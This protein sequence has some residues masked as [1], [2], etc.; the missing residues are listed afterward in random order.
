MGRDRAQ[1]SCS[2]GLPASV[3]GL[4]LIRAAVGALA[5]GSFAP[6]ILASEGGAS[7]FIPGLS[8]PLGGLLPPPGAY[9]D[10]TVYFYKGELKGGR[11]TPLGGNIVSDVKVDLWADFATG[12][13]VTPAEILG[14]NLAFAV[15]VPFGEPLVRAGAIIS[16]PLL[17]RLIGRPL[18]LGLSDEALNF[19][20]PVV[21]SIIG[22]HLGKWHWKITAS[23]S[24]PAGAYRPGELSNVALNRWIGDVSAGVTYLD[25]ELGIDLS[26]VGGF[27][28]NGENPDTNYNSG[29]EL[30]LEAGLT[31]FL[32][33]E[34]S[35][36]AIGAHY[37]QVTGDRGEGARLGPYKGR[38]TAVG[39]GLGYTFTLGHTP[40]STRVKVL[41]EVDVENRPQGTIGWVQVSFPLWT[42]PPSHSAA[43]AP[44]RARY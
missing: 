39:G 15:S 44:V 18:A 36:S 27:T 12:L 25:P 2:S 3:K 8:V 19:G 23:A 32:T 11:R 33:K 34:L 28:V 41:R 24:I 16:G 26:A 38:V 29:E 21:S 5:I 42:P 1:H 40:V 35:V 37:Q 17:N 6:P 13:W 22:W 9:F 31:K 4:S 20:D 7:L 10:N 30:H 14:G 43:P